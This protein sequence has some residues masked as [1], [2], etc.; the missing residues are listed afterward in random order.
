M[1]WVGWIL[2]AVGA[3]IV[4]FTIT[5]FMGNLK[6]WR[7]VK[8]YPDEAYGLFLLSGCLVDE[9]PHSGTRSKYTGPFR[10]LTSNGMTHV[11][12][13]PAEQIDAIQ[14]RITEAITATDG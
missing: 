5:Y 10:F 14:K 11:V 3:V 4:W 9:K 13:I 2:F 7:L 8:D 12:Y 6:F 1:S